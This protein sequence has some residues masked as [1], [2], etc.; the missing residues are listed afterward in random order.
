M[1]FYKDSTFHFYEIFNP[2]TG[3]LL[4]SDVIENGQESSIPAPMRSFPELIDVGVMGH[5]HAAKYGLCKDFGVDCYQMGSSRIRS[6]LPLAKYKLLLE[7]CKGRVYQIVLGGSG[8]PVKHEHFAELIK[9]TRQAGIVPNLTTTGFQLTDYEAS[10]ISEYCGAVAVSYYSRLDES[11]RETSEIPLN[12]IRKLKKAGCKVNVHFVLSNET[13]KDALYRINNNLFP[14]GINGVIFLLYKP[15]GEGVPEKVL[16]ASSPE[17]RELLALI[18]EDQ[19]KF[20]IGFD[21]CQTPA[22]RQ[23]CDRL[24]PKSIEPC[25]AARFSMYVDSDFMAYPCSF[26][27]HSKDFQVDLDN[28]SVLEAWNSVHFQNFRNTQDNACVGCT[29][30][31]CCKCVLGHVLDICPV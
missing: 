26:A 23:I 12:A 29:Q 1:I 7:Q 27:C 20:R 13:I 5:C 24:N 19:N 31:N 4:R 11:F 22:L 16:S 2:E 21:T 17:Y 6:N 25:E 15:V 3:A 14:E 30:T 28:L 8:D 9:L 18:Q 10:L